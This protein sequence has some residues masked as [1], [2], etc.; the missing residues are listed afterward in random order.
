MTEHDK[1][2]EMP[3]DA[4]VEAHGLKETAAAGMSAAAMLAAGAGTAAA[5]SPSSHAT[6]AKPNYQIVKSERAE[7]NSTHKW[8]P[9]QKGNFGRANPMQKGNFGRRDATVKLHK[10]GESA[11]ADA[12]LKYDL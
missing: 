12:L 8:D 9:M 11:R 5:A 10:K 1:P 4:E 2:N 7:A 3:E 6:G